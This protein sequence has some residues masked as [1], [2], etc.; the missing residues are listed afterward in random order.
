[1]ISEQR[2]SAQILQE[3][4]LYREWQGI[5]AT[6]PIELTNR[7]R[8]LLLQGVNVLPP[9]P[10]KSTMFPS[11]IFINLESI[12]R[13]MDDLSNKNSR[14]FT[15]GTFVEKISSLIST[16]LCGA[17]IMKLTA[18]K[19]N[20]EDV[21]FADAKDIQLDQVTPY[22]VPMFA[23]DPRGT[24][25]RDFQFSAKLPNSVKNL[26]YVLNQGTDIST[27][28]IAPYMNFMFNADNPESLNTVISSYRDT[29]RE[30]IVELED[31]LEYFG[32]SPQDTE[33]KT[34][35]R[36]AMKKYLQYPTPDIRK[37][38]QIVSPIFPFDASFTIDGI[39]GFRYGDVLEFPGLPKKYTDN[40]VFLITSIVHNITSDGTWTTKISC[41]M[42]PSI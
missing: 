38:Q 30:V 8:E 27:E 17:V 33:V 9:I 18:D 23:N 37:S 6:T 5:H 35:L 10:E 12:K 21:L 32:R 4:G 15:Y 2:E 7:Q 25:V 34:N 11:R 16:S 29:H 31:A 22:R 3:K 14:R 40:T 19:T 24:I 20:P 1:M 36:S 42:R 13:I 39:N 26:S 41:I 28:E